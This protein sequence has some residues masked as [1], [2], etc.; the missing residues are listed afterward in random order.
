MS[1]WKR[2]RK[3]SSLPAALMW[4]AVFAAWL[5]VAGLVFI[6]SMS[7]PAEEMKKFVKPLENTAL[8]A[9]AA[10]LLFALTGLFGR[11][12]TRGA[13]GFA[14]IA[15]LALFVHLSLDGFLGFYSPRLHDVVRRYQT[16]TRASPD[17]GAAQTDNAKR[18]AGSEGE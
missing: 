12:Q 7:T 17:N 5:A 13:L 8:L 6:F 1:A 18:D 4:L 9:S 10:A 2:R 11:H 14:A 16:Y 3:G 15:I